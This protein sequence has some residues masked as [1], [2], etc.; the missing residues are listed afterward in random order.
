MSF[1]R[2]KSVYLALPI[3]RPPLPQKEAA[4]GSVKSD[5]L[6]VLPLAAPPEAPIE[7]AG[8]AERGSAKFTVSDMCAFHFVIRVCIFNSLFT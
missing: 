5:R 4:E 7:E 2:E 8:G 1:N 6:L 3:R